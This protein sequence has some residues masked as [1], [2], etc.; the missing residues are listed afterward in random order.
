MKYRLLALDVD[1]TLLDDGH[2]LS[3]ENEE[4]VRKLV[5]E[6]VRVVLFTGRAY[7]ALEEVIR[8]I[9]LKDAAATQ[10]GSLI[11]DV[12]EGRTLHEEM[13]SVQDCRMILEYCRENGFDPLLYQGDAVYSKLTGK[14]L[15]IFET[16]MGL[17]VSAVDEIGACY[18]QIPLGKILILDEPGRVQQAKNWIHQTFGGRVS[19][20]LAYDFSLEI[21]GSDKGRALAWLADYYGIDRKEIMAVGDG[22]NDR[23][24]LQT[25]GFSVAMGN[26]MDRVKETADAVTLT[27]NE[28][29]VAAAIRNYMK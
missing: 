2:R 27:N 20:E 25:A 12:P 24:M 7:P 5:A 11:L 23:N 16:C 3:D 28:N 13:I 4:A 8:R 17:K 6:G 21:G 29:G 19:A 22:E 9:G 1:G 14:Y 15:D 18:Q 26:A 10:N